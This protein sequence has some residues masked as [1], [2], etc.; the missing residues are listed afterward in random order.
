MRSLNATVQTAENVVYA[1]QILPHI[2]YWLFWAAIFLAVSWCCVRGRNF[3]RFAMMPNARVETR[4]I[5]IPSDGKDLAKPK[6]LPSS[7][8]VSTSS[9]SHQTSCAASEAGGIHGEGNKRHCEARF[10]FLGSA[11]PSPL[12]STQCTGTATETVQLLTGDYM[13]SGS[14]IQLNVLGWAATLC[15]EHLQAYQKSSANRKCSNAQCNCIGSQ[16]NHGGITYL[17]CPLHMTER[18]KDLHGMTSTESGKEGREQ[19]RGKSSEEVHK[20]HSTGRILPGAK[21]KFQANPPGLVSSDP[22]PTAKRLDRTV[23]ADSDIGGEEDDEDS[24]DE[25]ERALIPELSKEQDSAFPRRSASHEEIPLEHG[26]IG[27]GR[28]PSITRR[29]SFLS[30]NSVESDPGPFSPTKKVSAKTARERGHVDHLPSFLKK[31][32]PRSTDVPVELDA[33]SGLK[34]ALGAKPWERVANTIASSLKEANEE[35][36]ESEYTSLIDNT[37]FVLRGFGEFESVI[38]SGTKGKQ[39]TKCVR[40]FANNHKD[41]QIEENLR[42]VISNRLAIASGTLKWGTK[43]LDG[44]D[45]NTVLLS[46][47]LLADMEKIESHY[48]I[49]GKAET[50]TAKEPYSIH[51]FERAVKN[52][53]RFWGMLYGRQH[54]RARSKALDFLLR[55]HDDTPDLFC[56]NFLVMTWEEMTRDYVDKTIEGVRRLGQLGHA[57]DKQADLYRAAMTM[58]DGAKTPTWRY[59][60][61][62]DMEGKGGYWHR[63]VLPRME[64][65]VDKTGYKSALS[66]ILSGWGAGIGNKNPVKPKGDQKQD[67]NQYGGIPKKFYPAGKRLAASERSLAMTHGPVTKDKKGICWDFSAHCG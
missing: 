42:C 8:D 60:A 30:A 5:P 51:A 16:W 39:L 17:D 64:K 50:R 37:I 24:W 67:D 4:T 57:G 9:G 6:T 1:V 19:E 14:G 63:V 58:M 52:Q 32:L 13:T 53:I 43:R 62:F 36:K 25:L 12:S 48:L 2:I 55:L 65:E 3:Y 44:V 35:A 21:S 28:K 15:D 47:F 46:D 7:E 27:G 59:P 40:D 31:A 22:P 49:D 38:G 56:V 23:F 66:K 34:Q 26:E 10:L 18:F 20:T 41:K 45:D 29:A 61:T 33:D 54:E 11:H